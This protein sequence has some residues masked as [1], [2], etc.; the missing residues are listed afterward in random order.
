[1]VLVPIQNPVSNIQNSI[2]FLALPNVPCKDLV[3]PLV[4]IL[5]TKNVMEQ[6]SMYPHVRPYTPYFGFGYGGIGGVPTMWPLMSN[7]SANPTSS[8]KPI[9]II[10]QV[11]IVTNHM[12]P[13]D[14]DKDYSKRKHHPKMPQIILIEKLY[15]D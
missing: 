10:I 5:L 2:Y 8:P 1:L 6:N 4:S 7:P 11:G 12:E 15:H 3:I 14:E 13:L 9:S